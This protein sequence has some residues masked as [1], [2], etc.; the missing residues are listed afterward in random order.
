M[1]TWIIR[2]KNLL[3]WLLLTAIL[4]G[5][6][7]NTFLNATDKTAI[8]PGITTDGHYQIEMQCS[9]CHTDEKVENV[10][11]TSGVTNT[12]CLDCHKDDLDEA[13]DSH[14]VRKFKNPENIIFL[15]H[16]DAMKCV[17]CHQEHNRKVTHPMAVTIPQDYCAHCH[18]V[19]LENLDSH[20]DLSFLTCATSGCHNFHDNRALAPSFLRKHYG[21]ADFKEEAVIQD[22][23][24]LKRW[25]EEGNKE[26]RA[27]AIEEADAHHARTSDQTVIADWHQSAHAAAGINCS[28]CHDD[29]ATGD[30]VERPGLDS[31]Q[32]C[33]GTEVADFQRGKHGMRLPHPDLA[34]LTVGEARSPMH[35]D[36][37]HR[38]LSCNSCHTSHRYDRREAAYQAC[39]QCHDSEHVQNYENSGHHRKWLAEVAGTAPAG[40]GVSCATCHMPREDRTDGMVVN[41]N[42]SANLRPNEKMMHNVCLQCHGAQFSMDSLADSKLI[43][44]N[45]TGRPSES[46]P[47]ILWASNPPSSAATSASSR[48]ISA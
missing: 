41:H 42:Q 5:Y 9:A 48:F 47:G 18:E 21:E 28:D 25:L 2:K 11:T 30:W 31:C 3:L 4:G 43:E 13:N 32:L 33:H 37:S 6:L 23:D 19:T 44:N 27:L 45:F 46:H 8:L 34:P 39:V 10:F 20:K 29:P 14:P 15:E 38:T 36:A 16:I 24:A 1:P 7:G 12:G 22:A 17:T 40:S 35:K 26:R